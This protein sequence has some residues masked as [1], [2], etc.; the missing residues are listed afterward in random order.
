MFELH[1]AFF[2]MPQRLS[3]VKH[4]GPSELRAP[5]CPAISL[6]FHFFFW[7]YQANTLRFVF[8]FISCNTIYTTGWRRAHILQ[9]GVE[10]YDILSSQIIFRKRALYLVA[11]SPKMTCNLRHPMGLRHPVVPN[12]LCT[13][14]QKHNQCKRAAFFNSIKN[15]KC[16][17]LFCT[18]NALFFHQK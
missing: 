16:L 9:G 6:H 18:Q 5:V 1:P 4:N 3:A 7:Q 14:L 17:L 2:K 13:T 11:L 10:S 15:T 12:V 8:L